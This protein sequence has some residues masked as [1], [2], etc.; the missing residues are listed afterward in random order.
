[1]NQLRNLCQEKHPRL[2]YYRNEVWDS[3]DNLFQYFNITTIPRNENIYADSLAVSA[4]S[5]K[6]PNPIQLQYQIQVKYRSSILDNLKYWKVFEYDEKFN[7]FLQ[8]IG[9]FSS[10]Q[11]E[12]E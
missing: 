3:V 2:R 4:S 9:E 6:I 5:F 8:S 12:E 1:M 10:L 11:I 7:I